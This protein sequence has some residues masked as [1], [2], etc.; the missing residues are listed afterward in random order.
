MVLVGLSRK[1]ERERNYWRN[2]HDRV[3][4]EYQHRLTALATSAIAAT[5]YPEENAKEH[6]TPRN[7]A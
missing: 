6:T 5:N 7:E 3:V 2:E 4:A 1:L